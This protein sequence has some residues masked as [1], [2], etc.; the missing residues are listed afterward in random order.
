[1]A[2]LVKHE[3]GATSVKVNGSILAWRS[4]QTQEN[5]LPKVLKVTVFGYKFKEYGELLYFCPKSFMTHILC[6]E[7]YAYMI[8]QVHVYEFIF[9]CI[10]VFV[11]FSLCMCISAMC[12]TCVYM[13]VFL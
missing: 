6:A 4:A 13:Y 11:H 9:L 5:C 10:H 12:V 3:R 1:M 7:N 8:A 2:R